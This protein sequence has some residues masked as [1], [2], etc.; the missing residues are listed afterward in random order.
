MFF[1]SPGKTKAA[2]KNRIIA[3][4]DGDKNVFREQPSNFGKFLWGKVFV[5]RFKARIP[6]TSLGTKC[7]GEFEI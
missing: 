4:S 6:E 1:F 2:R 3:K 5:G 7:D